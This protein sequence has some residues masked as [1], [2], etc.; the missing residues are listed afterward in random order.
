VQQPKR[1]GDRDALLIGILAVAA[2]LRLFVLTGSVYIWD[3]ER[4]WL[5]VA[6]AISFDPAALH[7]PIRENLHSALTA[8]FVKLGSL[9]FGEGPLGFKLPSLFAGLATIWIV[10]RLAREAFGLAASRWAALLLTFNEYHIAVS[11]LALEKSFYL[12][13]CAAALYAFF[14]FQREL[15]ARWL[16]ATAAALAFAF[17]SKEIAGLLGVALLASLVCSEQ[18]GW[19][20]R[21]ETAIAAGIGLLLI[22]PDLYWNFARPSAADTAASYSDH[23]ARVSGFGFS[24]QPLMFFARDAL[25]E[26]FAAQGVELIDHVDEYP[27]M[28]GA[29]G[30]LLVA[31]VL[32]ALLRRAS[33]RHDAE[34]G[35]LLVFLLVVA[36]FTLIEGSGGDERLD[37]TVWHWVDASAIAAIPLAGAF[38]ARLSGKGIRTAAIAVV[39]LAAGLATLSAL[40]NNLGLPRAAAALSPASLQPANSRLVPV[41]AAFVWCARCD[42][43]PQLVAE[44]IQV[45]TTA[46]TVRRALPG[47]DF[48]D[49][50]LGTDDRFFSLRA[51]PGA[52]YH[53]LYRVTEANGTVS[54]VIAAA[55]AGGANGDW[56]SR[57]PEPIWSKYPD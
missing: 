18:R 55:S 28:N 4:A 54:S 43:A 16:Y 56:R 15:N 50:R 44:Q 24:Y 2:A 57:Y 14:R 23:F 10:A 48:A 32:A 45:R 49:L 27:S 3:E 46:G 38:L 29:W 31:G 22:S 37:G 26:L 9:A 34:R 30:A 1:D 52:I 33:W 13:F 47:R 35:L 25:R 21:R 5:Y 6:R 41:H 51:A 19:L 20:V 17:L 12:L 42:P 7:L 11:T 36:F 8:Y 53:V 40:S 39:A